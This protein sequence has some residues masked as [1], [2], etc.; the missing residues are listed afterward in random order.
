MPR[1]PLSVDAASPVWAKMAPNVSQ[2]SATAS[3]NTQSGAPAIDSR[4]AHTIVLV[5]DGETIVIGGLIKNQDIKTINKI[6]L[7]GDL[8]LLGFAF[9]NTHITKHK[10]EIVIF[11]TPKIITGDQVFEPSVAKGKEK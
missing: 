10:T 8:P 11:L 9:R 2:P 6:P 7:L 5:Q 3:A 4:V 1:R